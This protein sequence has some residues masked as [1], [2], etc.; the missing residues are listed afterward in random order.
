MQDL[1]TK[2]GCTAGLAAETP[3]ATGIFSPNPGLSRISLAI[4]FK[5][6]VVAVSYSTGIPSANTVIEGTR[7][8][9]LVRL[10]SRKTNGFS[11]EEVSLL[12]ASRLLC[13]ELLRAGLGAAWNMG[14]VKRSG[15]DKVSGSPTSP[16]ETIEQP[17]NHRHHNFSK[18][19][20]PCFATEQHMYVYIYIYTY[21]YVYI[22]ACMCVYIYIYVGG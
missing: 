19:C 10:A 18:T 15:L 2:S 6:S 12:R 16:N 20:S 1:S 5:A 11:S 14:C 7:H 22:H 17:P 9:T 8:P 13:R 21:M 4:G 3:P